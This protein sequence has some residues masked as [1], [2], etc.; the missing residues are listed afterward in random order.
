M[1]RHSGTSEGPK[2]RG[3]TE[4][5]SI[6]RP[7]RSQ[8]SK[9]D[10]QV[11]HESENEDSL[12]SS[13]D[14][15]ED[16]AQA[17]AE[18]SDR[19]EKVYGALLTI[20]NSEHPERKKHK[21]HSTD[22]VKEI[23]EQ[24]EIEQGMA[25][26]SEEEDEENDEE[27]SNEGDEEEEEEPT[28]QLDTFE[29]H[30]NDVSQDLVDDISAGFKDKQ[31]K[32]KS[33][34]Y[35]LDKKE[36]AI[37][38][39]P[40]L[41][42]QQDETIDNPVLTSSYDSYF[43]KQRL[44]IQNDLLD[45]SKENLTPLKKKLLDPMFQ[46]K[47]VLCEYTNYEN[48]E[49]EYRELYSLHVLNHI[50]KTRDKILKDNQRLQENDDLECLD[51]G[52]T[53]PK[54]LI[55]VPTR[56]TAYQV[57]ETIIEKSGLDQIDKKGKFKDQFFDDSLPPTSKPKSFRHV[58]KGNTNDF[59][60]LGM[61]FTRKAIKL[62]SN[63]YQSDI[64]ICSPLGIQMILENTDKKKRQDDFLSSIEVMIVDQLHSI[65]YQNIS[66]VYTILEHINKIPQ[67]QREADFS[68]IRM[69]YINDQAKFL[70]QTMLFTRYISPTANAIINGKCH[71]MAG[72]W[73]NNQIISSEDSSIGQLG[74][75]IKQI[76]QR[77]DLVGGT[78]V[79][80][81]DY[82]FKYFTSV[83]MQNIVKSTG[84]ED[85]ILVYIPEY[86]DYMRLRNYMK[87][88]TT[89]LFSEINEY[90]TQKQLDSN[91]SMFQQGRTKVLLYTERLHHYRR[92]ELKGIK[93]VIFYKPP[94]NPEFYNEV[95][96]FTA[97]NAF[98]GKS[99]INISTIRTV[100]SKLDGLALQRIVG[101]KRAAILCHGQNESYDFK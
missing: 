82:R 73:K 2:K 81:S 12:E 94:T 59:F 24:E 89:I 14:D 5:R 28:D 75:K 96:R 78:V 99:D 36:S 67:Q 71:N 54:V 9:H 38:G 37:F 30:F 35:S 61:K 51:Q 48:D 57:V 19:K 58:F 11:V 4:L 41:L 46:Y 10:Q 60:V 56:D 62:Y 72:R 44:K 34:K 76:F 7:N 22:F 66:H 1:A 65:E 84:Y 83:V 101:S 33:M 20:L 18:N 29:S 27:E 45:S 74:I 55:V 88:K 8:H 90:S 23:D 93:S 43:I 40:L 69:W 6:R 21:S 39:K 52:F 25:S 68:R 70:R 13:S 63:F 16:I 50:Y 77:F 98:L 47:D 80:E 42:T 15:D 26:E 95:I 86:T 49:K 87:E 100:Y 17:E 53:R 31:I 32:Y 79:D 3:R 92:Y 64:I 85:G 91:R 97:K